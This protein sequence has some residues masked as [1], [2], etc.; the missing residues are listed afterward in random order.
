MRSRSSAGFMGPVQ[1]FYDDYDQTVADLSR[2]LESA[3]TAVDL[4]P[5]MLG[6]DGPRDYLMIFQNNAEIRAT[7][8]L[9]GSWAQVHVDDGRL[10]LRRQGSAQ[11]FPA[12]AEV[13]PL[14]RGGDGL[15]PE[16]ARYFQDP[17]FT[18]DFPRAAEVFDASGPSSIPAPSSTG[19]SPSTW[20]ACPTCCAGSGRSTSMAT[21]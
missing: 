12:G 2:A 14:T 15:R 11:S 13:A 18:P 10:E 3:R 7:A 4:A 8:G 9:P 6:G 21:P 19:S 5:A 1:S 20:S 16:L 17:N